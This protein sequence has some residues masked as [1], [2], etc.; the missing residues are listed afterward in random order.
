M[1]EFFLYSLYKKYFHKP[2]AKISYLAP[3]V[4]IPKGAGINA[5]YVHNTIDEALLHLKFV[6]GLKGGKDM[7]KTFITVNGENAKGL[8]YNVDFFMYVIGLGLVPVNYAN[9]RGENY[10]KLRFLIVK[11]LSAT[12]GKPV[13]AVLDTKFLSIAATPSTES[14]KKKIEVLDALNQ[15]M[16]IARLNYNALATYC[17][18]LKKPNM[19]AF[20]INLFEEA[21]T[22]LEQY[23][24]KIKSVKGSNIFFGKKTTAIGNPLAVVYIVAIVFLAALAAYG[25]YE[26]TQLIKEWIQINGDN[27]QI[28]FTEE[29]RY[30]VELACKEG[31]LSPE[32]CKSLNAH[33]D[34]VQDAAEKDKA[35]ASVDKPGFFDKIQNILLI[36]GGL[37]IASKFIKQ[38]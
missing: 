3:G 21:T 35:A 15:Q 23:K 31:R 18:S 29:Q 12:T 22:K 5:W 33:L 9:I 19:S 20:E 8:F 36:G 24:Q 30:K 6:A 28:K 2:P 10:G 13:F 17:E 11:G 27:D 25:I 14:N 37:Y 7:R 1:I 16:Q 26:I 34:V 32:Q 4:F 38:R